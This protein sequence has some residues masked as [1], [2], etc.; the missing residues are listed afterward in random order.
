MDAQSRSV[1]E[2][3]HSLTYGFSVDPPT[4][5]DIDDGFPS[6]LSSTPESRLLVL[7]DALFL[8]LDS[9]MPDL[10]AMERY[11]T[12]CDELALRQIRSGV[13]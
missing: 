13:A 5:A 6:D 8:E 10:R 7:S 11:L 4:S 3:D 9:E 1:I 12:L 2:P